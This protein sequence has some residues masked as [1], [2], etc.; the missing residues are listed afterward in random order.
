MEKLLFYLEQLIVE[1]VDKIIY[2]ARR[3]KQ[4]DT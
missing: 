3:R 2:S 1:V 4:E